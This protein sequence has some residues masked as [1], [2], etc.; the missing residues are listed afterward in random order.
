MMTTIDLASSI[1]WTQLSQTGVGSSWLLMRGSYRQQRL[2]ATA[3][4]DASRPAG[5]WASWGRAGAR[6]PSDILGRPDFSRA[7]IRPQS[8]LPR[9]R[10]IVRVNLLSARVSGT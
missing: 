9:L 7:S 2:V 10:R 1:D 4:S 3:G 8:E 6:G 5:R